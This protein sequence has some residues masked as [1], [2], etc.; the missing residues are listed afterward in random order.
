VGGEV[1]EGEREGDARA[2][3]AALVDWLFAGMRLTG[4]AGV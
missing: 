3:V 2:L 1:R 4:G